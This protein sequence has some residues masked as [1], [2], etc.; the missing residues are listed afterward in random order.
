RIEWLYI[1][2]SATAAA[3]LSAGEIDWWQQLPPDFIPLVQADPAIT[4]ATTD[5]LGS[6]GVLR[7]NHLLPPF[8]KPQMRQ[9]LLYAI[10][11]NDIMTALAGDHRNWRNCFSYYTCGTPLANDA[12]NAALKGKR[13]LARAK[14]LMAEAGYKGERIVLLSATDQYIVNSQALVVAE[15]LRQLGL[16]VDLQSMDWGTLITRRTSKEGIDK[17]GWNIF[18]TWLVGPDMANPALNFA[19]RASGEKAWFGWPSDPKLEALRSSWLE[20]PDLGTQKTLAAAIQE[21]AFLTVPYIPTGQF[22][23]PTAYRNSLKGVINS[24]VVFMWNVEKQ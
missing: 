24:P 20:A 16:N 18:F 14:A 17:G 3:A 6:V 7:F 19:L 8:D 21:Q 13:D 12:G 15:E 5:P 10:D 2:D 22:F 1:P 11:Q 23:I 9:A 4:V